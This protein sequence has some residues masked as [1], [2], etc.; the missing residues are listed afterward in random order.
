MKRRICT[1]AA[2]LLALCMLLSGCSQDKESMELRVCLEQAPATLDP[3]LAES[4]SERSLVTHLYD[5]LMRLSADGEDGLTAT[6]AV[7]RSY[8]VEDN[9][10]GTQTYTFTLRQDARWSDGRAV[11]AGDFVYAWQRLADPATGSDNASLLDMVSGYSEAQSKQDGTLLQVSAPDEHTFVVQ[12][13]YRCA[14]FLTDVCTAAATMP[15]RSDAAE[16]EDWSL[17]SDTLLTNG[18]YQVTDWEEGQLTARLVE[19]Y[20]DARRLG[21]DTLTFIFE[22]NASRRDALLKTDEVDF[23]ANLPEGE[24]IDPYPQSTVLLLNQQAQSVESEALRQALSLSID[25]AALIEGHDYGAAEGL[26]PHGLRNT[27]GQDFRAV[28]GSLIDNDPETYELRCQQAV[29]LLRQSGAQDGQITLLYEGSESATA[30]AKTLQRNWQE[31]LGVT[32]LLRAVTAQELKDSVYAGEFMI[33]LVT[34]QAD[35]ADASGL[36]SL[37]RGGNSYFY[38]S[39]YDMLLRAADASGQQTVRDAYLEDAERLLVEDGWVIPLYDAHRHSG[40]ADGLT[41]LLYDGCGVYDFRYI[42]RQTAQ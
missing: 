38:A 37:W 21:P 40:L 27:M 11:T 4:D 9:L 3:A 24:N 34:L 2:L 6:C 5:N 14:Y 39:A 8:Q 36:L 41:G 42:Q 13:R 22:S 29:E 20:Y 16:Q 23:A 32:V 35:R 28:S 1:A 10:D 7:A 26:V 18:A 12:L 33:A 15:V 25:R 31:Q 19:G 30:V 17:S